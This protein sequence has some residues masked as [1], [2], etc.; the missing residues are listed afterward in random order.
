MLKKLIKKYNSLKFKISPL[1]ILYALVFTLLG[2]T[3]EGFSYIVAVIIHEFAH[4]DEA[5][6]RGY[7]LKSM[8]LSVFG[9]ALKIDDEI[10][11]REDE[12]A[13]AI[14]GP[15]SNL[16][17]AIFFT[18]L[19]WL[20]PST[21]FFTMDFVIANMT[22]FCFN[23][24]P[25][26]PLDGG[27]VAITFLSKNQSRAKAFKKLRILGFVLS[28]I[29]F[30]LC[31]VAIIL[32]TFNLSFLLLGIFILSSTIFPDRSCAYQRLYATANLTQRLEKSLPIKEIAVLPS[33]S[34][35]QAYLMLSTEFYTCFVLVDSNLVPQVILSQSELERNLS[36][37]STLGEL[38]NELTK[39]KNT[40]KATLKE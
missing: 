1:L 35:K 19:W 4:A 18:A 28:A 39:S 27:R 20:F 17:L 15:M 32:K 22:V 29:L 6:K 40:P 30:L 14:A 38:A 13:I 26:Y 5:K 23:L 24:L 2:Q 37:F 11:S 31:I 9:A 3:Y 10:M 25:V 33:L 34:I 21:Y 7:E 8:T 16:F 12:R 36:R